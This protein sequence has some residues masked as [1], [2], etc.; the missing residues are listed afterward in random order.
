MLNLHCVVYL[1]GL[2]L[3]IQHCKATIVV[4]GLTNIEPV[5]D[6]EVPVFPFLGLGVDD[7]L[8]SERT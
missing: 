3:M 4:G 2:G 7:N 8:T 6:T 1:D 5:L